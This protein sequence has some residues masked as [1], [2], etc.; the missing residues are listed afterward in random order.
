MDNLDKPTFGM[1][2]AVATTEDA[3]DM[4]KEEFLEYIKSYDEKLL[5]FKEG[6]QPTWFYFRSLGYKEVMKFG[7]EAGMTTNAAAVDVFLKTFVGLAKG[8][9]KMKTLSVILAE[10]P[11]FTGDDAIG[12]IVADVYGF[13]ALVSLGVGSYMASFIGK[14]NKRSLV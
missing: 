14:K 9:G 7:E 3:L 8:E 13:D 12:N 5:K 2:R 6:M 4:T 1:F 11:E 10:N